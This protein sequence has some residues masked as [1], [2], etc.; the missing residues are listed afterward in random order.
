MSLGLN[1]QQGEQ[2]WKPFFDWVSAS[3]QD[4]TFRSAPLV[5]AIPARNW[6]DARF[7]KKVAPDVMRA[8]DRPG[9]LPSHSWWSGDSGQIGLFWHGY[10]SA[11]LPVDLLQPA[12]QPRLV[13]ALIAA[14]AL[15]TVELHFNKGLAGAPPTPSEQ[16]GIRR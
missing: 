9:A 8:D 7:W 10:E 16:R 4:Y 2:V 13:D 1:Q 5:V 12:R 6:W 11:W 3:P 14:S 15:W